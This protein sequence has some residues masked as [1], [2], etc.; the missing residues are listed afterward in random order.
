MNIFDWLKR[1]FN[2]KKGHGFNVKSVKIDPEHH[3]LA[4]DGQAEARFGAQEVVRPDGQYDEFLPVKEIQRFYWGDTMHCTVYGTENCV[5]TLM[6]A[7]YGIQPPEY[8]ERYLGVL[9]NIT[10]RGGS[11]HEV[12]E[13]WRKNGNLLYHELPFENVHSFEEFNSP[14]PMTND[15]LTKGREWLQEWKFGHEWLQ[16]GIVGGMAG[17]IKEALKYS[18]VGVGVYAWVDNGDG[19]YYKPSWAVD[20][21]WVMCYGYVEGKYWKIFDH[22]DN[23]KKK[24]AWDYPW[25]FAKKI[26]LVKIDHPKEEA[27]R[28]LY[29]R[30]KGKHIIRSQAQGQ[31][32]HVDDVITFEGWWTNSDWLKE[33]LNVELRLQE[34]LGNFIGVSENDFDKLKSYASL[35]GI[36]IKE[37]KKLVGKIAELNKLNK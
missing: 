21:H 13:Q 28:I 14:K 7:K 10:Q 12:M 30:L 35:A 37:D 24:V 33:R 6:K 34:K 17:A 32:Y 27:G 1:L 29:N 20:N 11:P 19:I 18:P 31:I 26:T 5:Q 16:P 22:Y 2:Q 4:G 9:A 25:A 36:D 15:L 3:F 8:T 23:V